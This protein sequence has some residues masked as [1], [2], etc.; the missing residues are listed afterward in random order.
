MI[1]TDVRHVLR[2]IHALKQA[3]RI[4][5]NSRSKSKTWW[6]MRFEGW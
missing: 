6:W 4:I 5:W 3:Q 1:Q 2:S